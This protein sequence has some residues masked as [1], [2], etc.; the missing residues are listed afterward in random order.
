MIR[1]ASSAVVL[2]AVALFAGSAFAV[3]NVTVNPATITNGYM[4]VSEIPANGGA[5]LWGSPWGFGDLNAS[6]SGST[7]KM[8]PNTIGD[9]DPYWYIGGGGPGAQ[10]NKTMDAVAYAEDN[11]GTYAGQ[12]V[13]FMGHVVNNNLAASHSVVAF[14][15]DFAPDFSS[16]NTVT[17]PVPAAGSSFSIALNTINDPARHVQYGFEMVGPCVWWTDVAAYGD[18]QVNPET[19][20]ASK[21]A[22]WGSVKALFR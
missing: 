18:I 16:V 5:F 2:A 19:P 6:F 11:V 10:G 14:I 4:N 9:P 12:T 13:V 21:P 22:T 1:R 20:V 3:T 8:T 7:F 17:V 15:K